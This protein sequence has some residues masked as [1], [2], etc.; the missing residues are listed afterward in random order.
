[1]QRAELIRRWGGLIGAVLFGVVWWWPETSLPDEAQRLAA[2]TVLMVVL[3]LTQAIPIPATALI[4]LAAYPLL[5]ILPIDAVSRAYLDPNVFLF[6]GGFFIALGIEKWNLHRRM[7][8]H[9]VRAIGFGPRRLVYGFMLATAFLSMWISNTATSML[10]LPIGLALLAAVGEELGAAGP[11]DPDPSLRRLERGLLLGIAYGASI[12]GFATPIGTPTNIAYLR[13]WEGSAQFA[14]APRTSTAEWIACFG[15]LSLLLLFV[16]GIVLTWRMPPLPGSDQLG[17]GFFAARLKELGPP[18]R[19][20]LVMLLLFVT[21]AILWITR[22]PIELGDVTVVPGWGPRLQRWLVDGLGAAPEVARGAAHDA[23]VAMGMAILMFCV[24]AGES[25]DGELQ[26]M[27]DWETVEAR[28]PWG[29]LLL[30]GGGFAVAEAFDAT[31]LS[32]WVGQEFEANFRDAGTLVLIIGI[33]LLST[34]MTEF[35]TNVVLINT[36]LPVLAAAA[37]SL[38]IDPRLLLIP[39]TIS[40][41]CAFMLPIATPPNAIVFSSGRLTMR[42]MMG[43]GVVLNFVGVALVTLATFILLA[44]IF[45]ISLTSPPEWLPA[46]PQ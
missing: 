34:F 4:P 45:G 30:I 25:S 3:W 21:T 5:G 32:R 38:R 12:G 11:R 36:L 6:M 13:F 41:S 44:P 19:Q 17:R 23:V 43:Y 8:L 20:E 33:C 2:V 40:A 15:P 10:M 9:I 16:T 14:D 1:M 29:M 35:T 22:S 27:M 18:R 42:D 26:R 7:A 31:G 24:P 39:A 37:I 28:M 46:S